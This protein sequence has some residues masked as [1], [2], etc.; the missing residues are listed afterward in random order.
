MERWK[1]SQKTILYYAFP[2][3]SIIIY[4]L[5]F[6]EWGS[7]K[8][9]QGGWDRQA[10]TTLNL[11]LFQVDSLG[12][13]RPWWRNAW[14]LHKTNPDKECTAGRKRTQKKMIKET[15]EKG[16]NW[17]QKLRTHVRRVHDT[18]LVWSRKTSTQWPHII[19]FW[20]PLWK[21]A[22]TGEARWT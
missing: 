14:R 18:C 7:F 12:E 20:L 3:N 11:E 22:I 4:S 6:P 19:S 17:N 2:S 10:G 21:Q 5:F 13:R 15:T 16:Q 1:A 8:C 9:V